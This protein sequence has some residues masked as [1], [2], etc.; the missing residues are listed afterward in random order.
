MGLHPW[1]LSDYQQQFNELKTAA[2][3]PNV[4]AIGECGLDRLCT[5]PWDVQLAAFRLQ[6][7]LA[8][9][10]QKP[11]IIH[12]VQAFNELQ[13]EFDITPPGVPII[14]HGFNKAPAV[15]ASLIRRGTYLSFGAALLNQRHP[16]ASVLAA[17]PADQFFLETDDS[18]HT[19]IEIYRQAALVRYISVEALI[20]QLESNFN[21]VF[22]L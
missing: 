21:K 16:A 18:P 5:T 9:V 12:C 14:I 15:A 3:H 20:L 8:R 19:I 4:V 17:T 6:I 7:Q 2:A 11:L 13:Q 10:L 1:Y 22:V